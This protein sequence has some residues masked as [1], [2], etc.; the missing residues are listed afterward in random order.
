MV[1]RCVNRYY[2]TKLSSVHLT[3]SQVNLLRTSCGEEEYSIYLERAKKGE[4]VS[5][6]VMSS[7]LQLHGL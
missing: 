3:C 7:S 4:S 5:H 1:Q 2:Q 6:S